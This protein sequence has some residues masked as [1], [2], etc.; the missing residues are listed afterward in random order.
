M[1]GGCVTVTTTSLGAFS[2]QLKLGQATFRHS[3]RL[4][5]AAGDASRMTGSATVLRKGR[6]SLALNFTYWSAHKTMQGTVSDGTV[7]LPFTAR[8]PEADGAPFAGDFSF[9]GDPGATTPVSAPQGFSV[10][11]LRV[12][13]T[14]ALVGAMLLADDTPVTF[15]GR[16]ESG[17]HLTI[18]S[19]LYRGTGSLLGVLSMQSAAEGD[20]RLSEL[21]WLKKAQDA[22]SKDRLYKT[23]FGPLDL[24]VF[25]RKYDASK[26]PL[27]LLGLAE[28]AAG[29]TGLTF[30]GGGAPD[31]E[32]RLNVTSVEIPSG[33]VAQA[34]MVSANPASVSLTVLKP[35]SSG[36]GAGK[37]TFKEFTVTK[38][39][40]RQT[41]GATFGE[42]ALEDIEV[43][44]GGSPG[45]T[46]Q[47]K[48]IVVGTIV[49]DGSGPQLV[50]YFLLPQLPATG[51]PAS[52]EKLTPILSGRW[53]TE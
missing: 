22:K 41:L 43:G 46:R 18:F 31:P 12:D 20:L 25:G 28:N 24:E 21:S 2:L 16:V 50:G 19:P 48:A 44:G 35:T 4:V 10:G 17:G 49:D 8:P 33:A 51:A 27:E 15:A 1:L 32:T 30:D 6:T 53:M 34:R 36:G 45:V 40:A 39:T 47:R 7:T 23:G 14:G 29:N 5:D 37:A 11:A 26:T 42:F 3:A 13:P 9:A 52:A 38:R